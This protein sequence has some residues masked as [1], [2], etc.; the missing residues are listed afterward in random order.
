MAK[1]SKVPTLKKPTLSRDAI[2]GFAE[3]ATG[4]PG[5]P[6]RAGA[7]KAAENG[8]QAAKSGLVPQGDV[9]LTANIRADLHLKLKIRAAEQRTTVGELIEQWVKS[10]P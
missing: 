4:G 2:L 9:R 7:T 5:K 1:E 6:V 3:G 10:W 8:L